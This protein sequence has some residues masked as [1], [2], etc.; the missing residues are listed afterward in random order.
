MKKYDLSILIPS[1]NEMFLART[2]EDLL[3]H[4]EGN[5]EIIIGLDGEWADPQI[6]DH[7]DVRIVYYPNSIGQRAITNQLCKISSAKYVLK[8]D[9]HTAWDQGFDV[10]LMAVMQDNWTMVPVMRNLHAFNWV[11]P[12]GHARYQ[13]PSGPCQTPGCS[14]PT[15][16]DVVWIPKLSPQSKSYCFDPEPHF[17]YFGSFNKRPE[18]KPDDLGLTETMSLQGSCFMLTR[19]KY[20]ELNICDEAFG[21]WGSQG[22]EVACKTWLSGGRVVVN[23]KTWYAHMFRTQGG[24]FSFPYPQSGRNVQNAKARARN[25][26]FDNAWPQQIYPISWLV[27]RFWP[28]D[29][30]NDADLAKIKER[31]K[32]F[33][34]S[35]GGKPTKGIIYFTDNK[36]PLKM[37]HA[38]QKQI[39][40]IG[41]PIVSASLK[42][43]DKMGKN[44]HLRL[45]RGK[46]TML[47][48]ILAALE[49]STSDIIYFCEHD[50][51]YP[52]EHFLF[53]P[54][55]K[56]IF[57]YDHNWW[58]IWPDGLAAHWDANQVSG[59]CAYREH[60]LKYYS[61][62]VKDV[63]INGF[64]G[65]YEPG[66]R[67]KNLSEAWKSTVPMVD[68]RHSGNLSRSHRNIN[69]FRDKSTSTGFEKSTI[70]RVPGWKDLR[71]MVY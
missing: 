21:S 56:D 12:E 54:P 70:E 2:V 8:C 14:K 58:K 27:E 34:A 28:I 48:Q 64:S 10:K 6:P 25:I 41:L 31:S 40:S 59:L 32:T 30:W 7:P 57:Y 65:G 26:F 23:H 63:E 3:E 43:M 16:R 20:W 50:C 33:K 5:T 60:L 44:I 18:G 42:P 37:A 22:I 66:G 68:I 1:R 51:L 47:K 29:H 35:A 45:E 13:G 49:A 62:R 52:P 36:L 17:Q 11:C 38:V 61:E 69:E 15:V 19:E 71:T 39:R 46:L 4:K 67:D 24:D 53:T 9:A 55:R